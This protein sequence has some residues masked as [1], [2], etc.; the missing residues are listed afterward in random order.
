MMKKHSIFC[1]DKWGND[2]LN[3]PE[4]ASIP[5]FGIKLIFCSIKKQKSISDIFSA[6]RKN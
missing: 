4:F 6:L 3:L 2:A 5:E 1:N